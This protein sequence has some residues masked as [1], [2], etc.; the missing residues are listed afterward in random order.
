VAAVTV[1]LAG[2]N[3]PEASWMLKA[4]PRHCWR[5][6]VTS[7]GGILMLEGGEDQPAERLAIAP[8]I[9]TEL[10]PELSG[11]VEDQPPD[12]RARMLAHVEAGT[13]GRAVTPDW[14]DVTRAFEVTE[15]ANR[16]V[17]RRRTIDLH[18]ETTS[19]R[20]Q[21]KTHM[22][23]LGCGLL[24]L[25]LVGVIALLLLGAAL[26][27]GRDEQELRRLLEAGWTPEEIAA[28]PDRLPGNDAGQIRELI[29]KME[30][31]ETIMRVARILVFLPLFAFLGLQ[32]LVF[33]ARPSRERASQ[34]LTDGAGRDGEPP[35]FQTG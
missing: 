35:E 22:T 9:G 24:S 32:L 20:S 31:A 4:A 7:E 10:A 17:R 25:T 6:M 26:G 16:S 19:E 33:V 28:A 27:G 12:A 3:L 2:E 5:L 30:R 8:P 29:R 34:R 21:F 18:F 11:A 23:A 1:S 14:T 13:A 15:A